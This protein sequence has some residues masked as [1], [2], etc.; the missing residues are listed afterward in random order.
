MIS[1]EFFKTWVLYSFNF[2]SCLMLCNFFKVKASQLTFKDFTNVSG[3]IVNYIQIL[4]KKSAIRY[5]GFP[6]TY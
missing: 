4:E 2:S 3:W 1:K 5:F 6:D